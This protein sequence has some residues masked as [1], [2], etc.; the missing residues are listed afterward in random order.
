MGEKK[1]SLIGILTIINCINI[2]N[3]HYKSLVVQINKLKAHDTKILRE[4]FTINS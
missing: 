3:R 4:L 2:P 1:L